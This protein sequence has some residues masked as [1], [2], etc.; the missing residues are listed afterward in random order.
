MNFPTVEYTSTRG[1]SQV[2]SF[3]DAV[4][5][6]QPADGGLFVPTQIPDF[7][8]QLEHWRGLSYEALCTKLMTP[9][10]SD[11]PAANLSRLITESFANFSHPDIAPTLR[12]GDNYVLE[13]FHGPT[14]AFKDF[15]LQFLGQ[16]FAYALKQGGDGLNIVCAT[17][18]DTGSAAIAGLRGKDKLRIFVMH[19]QDRPSQLQR[20]QMTTVPD[21]NVFNIAIDGSFDDC[22]SVLK[23]MFAN[24]DFRSAHR[25]STVN[26]INWG[27]I[28]AQTVYYF[29]AYLKVTTKPD[30]RV[31]YVTPT[32]NFGNL[33]SGY[34]AA[35][36]GLPVAKLIVATN[37]NDIL[38]NFFNSGQY[39]RGTIR[40]T[41]SPA[42]DIQVASNLE[43]YMYWH[44]GQD[45]MKVK[46]FMRRFNEAGSV[47][48]AKGSVFDPLIAACAID[49]Q[50]TT[51]TMRKFWQ[52]HSYH[53]DPH[54]AVGVAAADK[55]IAANPNLGEYKLIC[56]ATA[57]PAKFPQAIS[58]ATGEND[59]T[60]PTLEALVDLPERFVVLPASY[61]EVM[62]YISSSIQGV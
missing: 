51:E 29:Y 14:L 53:L 8:N 15:G 45:T 40:N 35:K 17:S 21:D 59:I 24:A 1:N 16:L 42:M 50:T 10:I 27:R 11:I 22:Q 44:F 7:S 25:M 2:L 18:G 3:L 13:L 34:I 43:R 54:T 52:N 12:C 5:T 57:H 41:L 37:N 56:L 47:H 4:C 19:P 38:S 32:G 26:S 46:S 30:E 61:S 60:H 49:D 31:V 23:A 39:V 62:D 20:L 28:L 33:L 55:I 58:D 36:M 48:F 6:G 9:F